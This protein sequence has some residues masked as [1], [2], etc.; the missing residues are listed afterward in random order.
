[1]P[2]TDDEFPPYRRLMPPEPT[3]EDEICGCDGRPPLKLMFDLGYNP[4]HCVLCN[5]EI[6]PESI[7]WP[8]AQVREIARWCGLYRSILELWLDSGE[9]EAWAD[10]ELS[11]IGSYLNRTGLALVPEINARR[12]CYYHLHQSSEGEEFKP[13]A[14]CPQC[15]QTL[16]VK[17]DWAHSSGTCDQCL[18]LVHGE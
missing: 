17:E 13:L 11:N 4:L 9:Y 15:G 5:C 8:D 14:N 12:R 16:S 7:D 18:I 10:T 2:D 6:R 3:P 1:M